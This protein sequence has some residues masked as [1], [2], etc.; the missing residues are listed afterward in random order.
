MLRRLILKVVGLLLLLVA[1]WFGYGQLGGDQ[2]I[3]AGQPLETALPWYLRSRVLHNIGYSVGYSEWRANPLWVSYRLGRDLESEKVGKRPDFRSDW[4]SLAGVSGDD[5][6]QSGYDRGHLA[7]NYA[8]ARFYG[9]RAQAETFLLTNIVPQRG[10]LNRKLWQRLEQVETDHFLPLF[11]EVWVMTGPIFAN[12]SKTL[13]NDL[14]A[15]DVDIPESFYKIY[16]RPA[17]D[18]PEG[19]AV[20]AIRMPQQVRGSEPL[21]RY[22]TTVDAIEAATWLDFFSELSDDLEAILESSSDS[23]AWQLKKVARQAARY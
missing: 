6:S 9:K 21:D 4:R 1:G 14:F 15:I 19:L 22:V 13:K 10:N 23:N 2:H 16:L 8:I 17:L 20:L 12:E 5:Y 7:P 3:Y 18:K 11:G